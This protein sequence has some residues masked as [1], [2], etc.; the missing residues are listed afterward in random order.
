MNKTCEKCGGPF[1]AGFT[2]ALGLIGGAKRE[3]HE[4]QLI[5]VVPGS[6]RSPNPVKAFQQGLADEPPERSY[7]IRGFRCSR[8][9]ALDLYAEAP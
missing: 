4:P 8:C 9:G 5:F 1:E 7:K 6:A 2:T 3:S